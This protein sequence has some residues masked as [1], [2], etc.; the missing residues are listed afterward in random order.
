VS[1]RL[2]V[3]RELRARLDGDARRL[4]LRVAAAA[5]RR[6]GFSAAELGGLGL[7]L[8]GDTTMI[9]LCRVHL[10]DAHVTDVL[11]F[12]APDD[13]FVPCAGDI[14]IDW[15]QVQRQA[16]WPGSSG[17]AREA[18]QL[19]VHGLVHLAGHDHGTRAQARRMLR[20]ERAAARAAGLAIPR[21]SYG[22][23]RWTR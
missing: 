5:G 16:I 9:E 19:L 22:G 18:A 7:R 4:L 13:P 12:P 6:L 17:W 20:A 14:A 15:E 1:V 3:D 21:R 10:G 8:V 23:D 11:S 2:I